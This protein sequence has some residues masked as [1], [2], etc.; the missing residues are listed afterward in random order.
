M[1]VPC[2]R[3]KPT[4]KAYTSIALDSCNKERRIG[5]SAGLEGKLK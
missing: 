5:F 1:F 3:K 2:A 4:V